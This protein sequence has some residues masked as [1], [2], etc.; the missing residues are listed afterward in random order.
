MIVTCT[1]CQTRY[2]VDEQELGGAAGRAVRCTN[3][4]HIWHHA[5]PAIEAPTG[6]TTSDI[7]TV[8][9]E[10]AVTEPDRPPPP[11]LVAPA[12]LPS[13]P[14]LPPPPDRHRSAGFGR[15]LIIV[16]VL[17]VVLAVL[18][19]IVARRQL[20]AMWPPAQRL[21][22]S[23]G[24]PVESAEAGLVIGKIAPARSGDALVIAGEIV[25]LGTTPREVPRL[26]VA[27][28]DAAEK[29]IQFQVADPPKAEL[30]PGES[31]H[32]SIPISHPVDAAA[33]VVVT[34]ASP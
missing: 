4:G 34:F 33:G 9:G 25:N 18:A 5:L 6:E 17:L 3:C 16:L 19:G 31:E 8:P 21:L 29:E 15:A 7:A 24:L 28:R 27:L 23:I 2:R 11:S 26:R 10:A 20:S 13:A 14:S 30:Q 12:R 32:F 22:A 1:A